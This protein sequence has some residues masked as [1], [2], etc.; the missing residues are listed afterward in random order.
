[1]EEE[2]CPK[3]DPAPWDG[4]LLEWENKRF[5]RYRVKR[6][7]FV[8]LTIGCVIMR[9]NGRVEKSGATLPDSLCLSYDPPVE[10]G[11]LPGGRQGDPGH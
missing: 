4:K 11:H 6:L 5:V 1:M 9:L 2:C 3:F 10:L 8:P 7:F